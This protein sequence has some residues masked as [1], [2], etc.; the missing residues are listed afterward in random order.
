[1]ERRATVK[2]AVGLDRQVERNDERDARYHSRTNI[3]QKQRNPAGK[4]DARQAVTCESADYYVDH[5]G[6]A[7]FDLRVYHAREC[8]LSRTAADNG[9]RPSRIEEGNIVLE[10]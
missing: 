7:C 4:P 5:C 3:Q 6:R 2:Q 8:L 1:H 9:S 10:G